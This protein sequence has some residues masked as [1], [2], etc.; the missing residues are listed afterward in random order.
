MGGSASFSVAGSGFVSFFPA[1]FIMWGFWSLPPCKRLCSRFA[2]RLRP[3]FSRSRRPALWV[4]GAWAVLVALLVLSGAVR[5]LVHGEKG[6]AVSFA[7][8]LLL[9]LFLFPGL[10]VVRPAVE[11]AEDHSDSCAL[12]FQRPGSGAPGPP[13]TLWPRRCSCRGCTWR[14]RSTCT[15][16]RRSW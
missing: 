4:F 7:V 9:L 16:G 14:C 8:D 1:Y 6:F 5:D 15:P 2:D 11:A 13:F 3:R 10:R 12:S